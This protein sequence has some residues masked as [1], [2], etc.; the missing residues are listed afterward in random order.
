MGKFLKQRGIA[1]NHFH[2]TA[3]HIAELGGRGNRWPRG[4]SPGQLQLQPFQAPAP[5]APMKRWL[6]TSPS[7]S[8]PA[9]S[10]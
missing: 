7:R 5:T 2:H 9:F 4:L 1:H 3:P 6:S 10:P 8:G